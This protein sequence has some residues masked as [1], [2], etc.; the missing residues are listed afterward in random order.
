MTR[1]TCYVL[2]RADGFWYAVHGGRDL[3]RFARQADAE[4]C[5]SDRVAALGLP[6]ITVVVPEPPA[7]QAISPR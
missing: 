5:A 2:T 3:G 7:S 1:S 4:A 6:G